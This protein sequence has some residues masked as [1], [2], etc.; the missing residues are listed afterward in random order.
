MAADARAGNNA[1]ADDRP[2]NP[3]GPGS[4]TVASAT[5]GGDPASHP[6]LQ[7]ASNNLNGDAPVGAWF[8]QTMMDGL[9]K[10]QAMQQN[11]A[12]SGNAI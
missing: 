10:Y 5:E 8:S 6:L 4:A 7:Q 12:Q 9:K 11:P 1:V 2:E 3:D